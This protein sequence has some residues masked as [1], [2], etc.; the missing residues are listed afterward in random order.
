MFENFQKLRLSQAPVCSSM[1]SRLSMNQ[2][3]K[4]IVKGFERMELL[5]SLSQRA[6]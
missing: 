5:K 4:R 2:A 6:T 3:D 1:T